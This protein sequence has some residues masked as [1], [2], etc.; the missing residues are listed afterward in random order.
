MMLDHLGEHPAADAVGAAIA[1]VLAEGEVGTRDMG[2]TNST[3]EV[4]SAIA[5]RIR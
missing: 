2:G 1:D 3:D 4:G 5:N